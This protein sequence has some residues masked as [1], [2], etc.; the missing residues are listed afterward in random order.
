[1]LAAFA[2]A[3]SMLAFA[4]TS[5][6]EAKAYRF[7]PGIPAPTVQGVP[8]T[9]RGGLILANLSATTSSRVHVEFFCAIDGGAIFDC[10]QFSG[11]TCVRFAAGQ[12]T[13]SAAYIQAK[14]PEGMH[15]LAFRTGLCD[16]VSKADCAEY[17]WYL[18]DPYSADVVYDFTPPIATILNPN[19][20]P[21]AKRPLL[22]RK[23]LVF[24]F[25]SNEPGTFD[26]RLGTSQLGPCSSPY[27][28]E[29][30][31]R[32]KTYQFRVVAV[33]AS[34]NRS[35]TVAKTFSVDIF[36]PKHCSRKKGAAKNSCKRK[37]AA[38]KKR[39]KRKHRLR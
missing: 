1:M 6:D 5:T 32:N 11:P 16:Q 26:C 18:G 33:D 38:A 2:L 28:L 14:L 34:G 19:A 8:S 35:K 3:A 13:C 29:H 7:S 36:K 15:K 30:P 21:T 20:G 10:N 17:D 9:S 37:N 22:N 31:L 27:V 25:S 4:T 39:W 23:N 24:E 12:H